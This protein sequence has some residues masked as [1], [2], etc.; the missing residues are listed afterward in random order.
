MSVASFVLRGTTAITMDSR[1]PEV[2]AV[3]I[4]GEL[5]AAVGSADEVR[6]ALGDGTQVVELGGAML[7][8]F[9]DAHHHYSGAAL[10]AGAPDL[11]LRP[12]SSVADVL[13]LVERAVGE[14]GEQGWLVMQGYDPA[15]LRERRAPRVEELDE[16]CGD[17][18][19]LLIAYSFHDGCLNSRGLVE[20]GW[21]R[22]SADPPNGLLL[23][24]R[25]GR[26]TGEVSEGALFLASARSRDSLL[27]RTEDAW[28]A[29]C[30]AHGHRLLAAGIVRVADAAVAPVYERLYERAAAE[31]RLPVI[32]HRMPVAAA[33]N[34]EPRL[35]GEPTGG[36]DP[37]VPVGPAKLF[38]DGGDRCAL[39]FS[40]TQVARAAARTLRR[41]VG[42]G[43]LAE[44]RA[45]S[46]L[47][48]RRGS[49]GLLHAGMLFWAQDALDAAVKRAG[50]HGLQVAQHA[51]GNEAIAVA[52]TALERGG[53]PLEGLPGRPRLEHAMF[54]DAPLAAR[55]A[56]V[57]AIAVVQPYLVYDLGDVLA[58]T[59]PPDP[60]RVKPLRTLLDRGVT[61]AGSSDY[62][63]SH[64][65]V[66]AA[67]RA[68]VT[69]RTRGG[70]VCEPEEAL[71]VGQ[72][73]HAYTVGGA[74]ALGVEHEAGTLEP[75]KRADIVVL[76]DDPRRVARDALTD[77]R[78]LRTYKGGRLVYQRPSP[79]AD[80]A[81][82]RPRP[83]PS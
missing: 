59:P 55:I 51:I 26:L 14:R 61:L 53:R 32:V 72:A 41:A 63:V 9:I 38:I 30:E 73:L 50:E 64:F 23:R 8:A 48:W 22:A 36:G 67:V 25:R 20:M 18:P 60:V 19:L 28:M 76:S 10:D 17:R 15:K 27:E 65:D 29:E 43:G 80:A 39:C 33:S 56:D 52:L 66:L 13:A 4:R 68:A 57:G 11:H 74:L 6:A 83:S 44:L 71:T 42:G 46:R 82:T 70:S 16:V 40:M 75:G 78:V 34:I 58:R 62:P 1:R 45:S 81:E 47:R 12:G 35:D 3:G 7:P 2:E 24:D 5:I 49:D 54:L 31:G 37:A 79:P 69:R 77:V 21:D